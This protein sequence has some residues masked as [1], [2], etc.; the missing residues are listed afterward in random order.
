MHVV[1]K[2]IYALDDTIRPSYFNAFTSDHNTLVITV[3]Y[4]DMK[5]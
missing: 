3:V 4:A 1:V 2:H 5:Y